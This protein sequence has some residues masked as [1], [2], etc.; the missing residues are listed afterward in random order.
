MDVRLI[1]EIA[2]IIVDFSCFL[3]QRTDE[4]NWNNRW[5]RLFR[6]G[7]MFRSRII[8]KIVSF[9]FGLLFI[10][11]GILLLLSSFNIYPI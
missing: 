4:K 8:N 3:I 9:L 1:G 11:I 5:Y 10:G 7:F 2:L 6:F